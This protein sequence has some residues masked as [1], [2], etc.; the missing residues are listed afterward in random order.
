MAPPGIGSS[1]KLLFST[2]VK[3]GKATRFLSIYKGR[4][5]IEP[6]CR[7]H[8]QNLAV[9][10][11]PS[12]RVH[13]W[14]PWGKNTCNWSL[15]KSHRTGSL[16][17]WFQR[18]MPSTYSPLHWNLHTAQQKTLSEDCLLSPVTA[19]YPI[20]IVGCPQCPRDMN[21]P[22]F[23]TPRTVS[24]QTPGLFWRGLLVIALEEFAGWYSALLR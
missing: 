15:F 4:R 2:L 23:L 5:S 16:T 19:T 10:Y 17:H 13:T 22:G 7:V 12:W 24:S 18:M 11:P 20:N 6:L 1:W 14:L 9:C 21:M 8:C 3:G